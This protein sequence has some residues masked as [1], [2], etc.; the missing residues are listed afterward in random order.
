MDFWKS[1]VYNMWHGDGEIAIID[2]AND[3]ILQTHIFR[4]NNILPMGGWLD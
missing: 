3:S 2:D 4:V 1:H